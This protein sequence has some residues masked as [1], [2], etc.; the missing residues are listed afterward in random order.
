MLALNK[1]IPC[2]TTLGNVTIK[3]RKNKAEEKRTFKCTP[4]W[5]ILL[6]LQR[7]KWVRNERGLTGSSCVLATGSPGHRR[8]LHPWEFLLQKERSSSIRGI[9]VRMTR[10][11]CMEPGLWVLPWQEL[12]FRIPKEAV[13]GGGKDVQAC[14]R[15]QSQ[16]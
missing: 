11:G 6:Y 4:I 16:A 12:A 2:N 5:G 15:G 1:I 3:H 8:N 14:Q 13:W 9:E 7:K 10:V